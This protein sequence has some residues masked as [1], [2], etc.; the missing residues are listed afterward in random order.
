MATRRQHWSWDRFAQEFSDEC[1]RASLRRWS[2]R[3][4]LL[5]AIQDAERSADGA[6]RLDYALRRLR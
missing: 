5:H 2:S 3:S 4:A 1:E 6:A